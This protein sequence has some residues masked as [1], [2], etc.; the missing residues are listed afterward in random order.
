MHA[1]TVGMVDAMSKWLTTGKAAKA[2]GAGGI[3]DDAP[4]SCR[5]T[6]EAD[7]RSLIFLAKKYNIPTVEARELV[8]EFK[9]HD[10]DGTGHISREEFHI[11]IRKRT[12]LPEYEEIPDH[13]VKPVR[14]GQAR[15]SFEEF[16]KWSSLTAWTEE[17]MQPCPY[18]RR[19]RQLAREQDMTLPDVEK[20]KRFFNE[21]DTD[22]SGEIDEDEFRHILYKMLHVR[23]VT[24]VPV[25]RLQRYWREVDLDGSGSI[26]FNEFLIWYTTSFSK[27]GRVD[28]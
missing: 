2:P 20:V 9:E 17:M 1:K 12:N 13:L 23:D 19:I 15:V 22:S 18:Q 27:D 8:T 3:A 16:L 6:A 21:F 10:L 28:L 24:D 25:K 4:S 14:K 11:L 5:K 7:W 26:G